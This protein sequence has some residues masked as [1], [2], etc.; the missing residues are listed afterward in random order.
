MNAQNYIF[1]KISTEDGV[2]L[3]DAT[4]INIRTDER[5]VSNSDGHF[6]ISGRL[7]DELRFVKAGYERRIRKLMKII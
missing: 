3:T 7:G 4:V 6:M 2:E 5:V 1:G